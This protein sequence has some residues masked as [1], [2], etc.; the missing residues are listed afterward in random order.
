MNEGARPAPKIVKA[1]EFGLDVRFDLK[2]L[3]IDYGEGVFGPTPEARSLDAIRGSLRE[4]Q[5][6]GP[7]PVY[8]I[9]MDVG[10]VEHKARLNE[11]MLLFGVVAYA[12]GRLGDEPVRS[13]GHVHAVSPHSGWSA[14]EVFEIWHGS[15]IIYGQEKSGDDPGRCIAVHAE[16]GNVVVM[17]PRWAHYVVNADPADEMIFGAWCDREYGFVYDEVRLHGGLAW[18]PIFSDSRS[19][20]W[21]PNRNYSPSELKRRKAREYPELGIKSGIPIYELFAMDAE[22]VGWVSEP[23]RV[24][25]LWEEFEP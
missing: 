2:S 1:S 17:P 9:A 8:N 21:M 18:F 13:Q 20:S 14:P 10:R 7:D 5:C 25:R 15:A 24:A 16:K 12:R 11:K 19:I 4:P 6:Q 3:G 22:S 23:A